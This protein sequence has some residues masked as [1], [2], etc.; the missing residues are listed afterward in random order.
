MLEAFVESRVL[1]G[2]RRRVEYAW[3]Q[4]IHPMDCDMIVGETVDAFYAAA[5]RGDAIRDVGGWLSKVASNK[6]SE[7]H[8]AR[9]SAEPL[10]PDG[11]PARESDAEREITPAERQARRQRCLAVAR[12]LLP[13]LSV[14]DNIRRVMAFIFDAVEQGVED[15]Q[16]VEV[17]RAL[18]VKESSIRTWIARGFDRLAAR[19]KEAGYTRDEYEL[20]QIEFEDEPVPDDDE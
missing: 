18:G 12:S 7:F 19:A 3:G 10:D 8:R 9:Q 11:H 5:N 4:H 17:A 16:P 2:L 15:L 1:E 20:I 6:A 13:L 14:S